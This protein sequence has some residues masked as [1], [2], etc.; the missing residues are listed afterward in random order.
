MAHMTIADAARYCGVSE[1]IITHAIGKNRLPARSSWWM[2]GKVRIAKRSVDAWR[3][4][5]E[6]RLR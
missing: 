6:S 3:T 1:Q 2:G 5:V 4:E